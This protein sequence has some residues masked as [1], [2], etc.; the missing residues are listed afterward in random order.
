MEL[1]CKRFLVVILYILLIPVNLLFSVV[2]RVS[3]SLWRICWVRVKF[4]NRYRNTALPVKKKIIRPLERSIPFASGLAPHPHRLFS[5][6]KR[7]TPS[8]AR[9]TSHGLGR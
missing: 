5:G 7:D 2:L 1:T 3:V 6:V 9:L 4:V 8:R